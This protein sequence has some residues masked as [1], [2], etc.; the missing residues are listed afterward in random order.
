MTEARGTM[1]PAQH[2]NR[3]TWKRREEP[4]MTATYPDLNGKVAVVTGGSRGIGAATACALADN[5]VDVAVVGRDEEALDRTVATLSER[6]VTAIGVI[7][8]CTVEA[9]VERLRDAVAAQLGEV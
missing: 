5:G 8:D 7:A 6:D 3:S 4:S 2:W 9:D 1:E